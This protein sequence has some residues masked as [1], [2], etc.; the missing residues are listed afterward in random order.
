MDYSRNGNRYIQSWET[1][2][3]VC[4]GTA[5]S[6]GRSGPASEVI[7]T[8]E[9]KDWSYGHSTVHG[10]CWEKASVLSYEAS[11]LQNSGA[12]PSCKVLAVPRQWEVPVAKCH[13]NTFWCPMNI[14]FLSKHVTLFDRWSM[15]KTWIVNDGNCDSIQIEEKY[16]KWVEQLRTD[17]YVTAL[18]L[19]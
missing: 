15:L 19:Q 12:Q 5:S 9:A 8:R 7:S 17:R 6:K 10:L 4:I 11:N 1:I 2:N 14:S 3:P 16:S 18:G 13:K